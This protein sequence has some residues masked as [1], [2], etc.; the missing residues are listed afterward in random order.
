[1]N[2][3]SAARSLG[4]REDAE[5]LITRAPLP[6]T[7]YRLEPDPNERASAGNEPVETVTDASGGGRRG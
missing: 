6:A 2:Q 3:G 5:V 1:V 4:V 7:G